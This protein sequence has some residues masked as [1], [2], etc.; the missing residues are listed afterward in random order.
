MSQPWHTRAGLPWALAVGALAL[1]TV[2]S[3]AGLLAPDLYRD[4][5]SWTREARATDVVTLLFA[6]P[7]LAIALWRVRGGSRSAR[8]VVAG[9]LGYVA[10]SYAIFAFSV[11]PNPA[12]PLYLAILG[13]SAWALVLGIGRMGDPSA[14]QE[15]VSRLPRRGSGIYLIAV[16]ILFGLLWASEIAAAVTADGPTE[17]LARAG[18]PTNP[19][20]ALDLA[21]ALPVVAY[22]GVRLL[23][24]EAGAAAT[25]LPALVFL[26]LIGLAVLGV[27]AYSALDGEEV[28]LVPVVLVSIITLIAAGLVLLAHGIRPPTTPEPRA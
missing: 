23:R 14:L 12:T 6:V 13:L 21:F 28:V 25:A 5:E 27:F 3:L 26:A 2:A 17:T 9:A 16:A 8:M 15:I 4:T 10:Y 20:W 11:A 19:I 18:L 22:G 1:A 24:A 7:L